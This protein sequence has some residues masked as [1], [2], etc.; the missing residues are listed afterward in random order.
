MKFT[1]LKK[2]LQ[3]Q[4]DPCYL[5]RGEDVF[6]IN[7]SIELIEKALFGS[8]LRNNLNKQV[9]STEETD[10]TSLINALNTMPFFAEKKLVILKHYDG[11]VASDTLSQ[12]KAYMQSACAST[13]FV[14]VCMQDASSFE[15][16]KKYC[17]L[18]DCARLDKLTTERVIKAK[19]KAS[20]AV[21]D[22]DALTLL[23]DYTNGYLSK[24]MLEID[25]LV[26]LS[27]GHITAEHVK[28]SVSKDLEYSIFE[29][30]NCLIS[31]NY[32][33]VFQIKQDLM[34]NRKTM[35]SVLAVIQNYY[36][37]LFYST[38]ST[39]EVCDIAKMLKVKDSAVLIA[40][41]QAVKIGARKLKSIVELCAELDYK[42][43]S[44]QISIE[45]ATDYLLGFI[46]A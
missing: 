31:G 17:T 16:L 3:S 46:I 44:S 2:T 25:K 43:K 45:N 30:T 40:K 18:V 7:S 4:I 37:R 26:A 36:R 20:N 41:Q 28:Q 12:L 15:S 9:F 19:L 23:M 5:I 1:E 29:L 22:Q 35:G 39:G 27:G 14:I 21:I 10:S 13:V 32:K 38:V 24:I 33:K 8:I 6:L 42:I 34:S 11:K